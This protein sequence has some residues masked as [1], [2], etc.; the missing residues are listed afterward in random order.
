MPKNYNINFTQNARLY[1]L[2]Y[3]VNYEQLP[4]YFLLV[5]RISKTFN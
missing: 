1:P 3:D 2:G 4:D 5:A